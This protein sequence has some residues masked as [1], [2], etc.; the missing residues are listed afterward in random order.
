[1]IQ[2]L[3][4]L[5]PLIKKLASHRI[6]AIYRIMTADLH[7][8]C[9]IL[10]PEKRFLAVDFIIY[11]KKSMFELKLVRHHMAMRLDLLVF[12][13]LHPLRGTLIW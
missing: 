3:F 5:R 2:P 8:F 12:R 13:F 10:T 6:L 7:R 11:V 4:N 9:S 1:M